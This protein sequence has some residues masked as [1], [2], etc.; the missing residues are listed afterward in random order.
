MIKG[1]NTENLH[2]PTTCHIFYFVI[3]NLCDPCVELPA[4]PLQNCFRME[5]EDS[6][7][8][9]IPILRKRPGADV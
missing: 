4:L 3:P 1:R 8:P 9:K 5:D 7:T 6:W 2:T